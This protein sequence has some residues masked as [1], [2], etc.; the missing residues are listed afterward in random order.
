MARELLAQ[1][2][3]EGLLP[4]DVTYNVLLRGYALQGYAYR[5]VRPCTA[6]RTPVAHAAL[7]SPLPVCWLLWTH[8]DR[9]TPPP[10]A[11]V[12]CSA[13]GAGLPDGVTQLSCPLLFQ[14]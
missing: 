11:Y 4:N 9:A 8:A 2:R 10:R 5:G 12:P 6:P 7:V 14:S 1:M 3:K 13:E